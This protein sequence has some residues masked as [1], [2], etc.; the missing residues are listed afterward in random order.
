MKYIRYSFFAAL[1]CAFCQMAVAQVRVKKLLKAPGLEI[2]YGHSYKGH[3]APYRTTA[4]VVGDEVEV[5]TVASEMADEGADNAMQMA[6]YYDYRTMMIYD[7]ATLPSGRRVSTAEA[8][9]LGAGLTAVEGTE[10]ILGLQCQHLRAV[11]NSNTYDV[12]VTHDLP[13]CN[14]SPSNIAL[15]E[16]LVLRV[17]RNGDMVTEAT[18]IKPLAAA[19]QIIPT[20]RGEVMD[21]YE[22]RYAVNRAGVLDV[23]VF[24]QA[25]VAFTGEKLP[26][27]VT[28]DEIYHAGGGTVVLRKVTLPEC[29]LGYNVYCTTTQYSDGDAYDRVGSV[30]VIP[31]ERK[32]SFLDMLRDMSSVPAQRMGG[33]DYPGLISTADYAV[34]LELQRFFTGFGV[35][36]YNDRNRIPGVTWADSVTY[37]TDVTS[38][39][40]YLQGEVWLG[41]YVGNWDAKG[42]RLSV[43]LSYYPTGGERQYAAMPLFNTVNYAEQ[44]G[45]K[46][47]TFML[48]DSLTTTFTLDHDVRDAVLYYLTSGHGGWGGGDEF[49]QKIN[50][51]W[52]DGQK[53][54]A[55]IPWRDDCATYR[56]NNPCSGDAANGETSS[57]YSR[58]NWCPG[59]VTNPEYIALGDLKAGQHT[60]SVQIPQGAPEGGSNS[61]WCISGT[62]LYLPMP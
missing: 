26:A 50:T 28:A 49:N 21:A 59:T 56:S 29:S 57:D 31:T 11:H 3:Q 51:I 30:F 25:R 48:T 17:V 16:G 23:R 45:Q 47:P 55:F 34:P 61:Y 27:D 58:S 52:L 13:A 18:A 1:L 7:V 40:S 44:A 22:Y 43:T 54:A 2:V 20:D 12:W 4:I 5:K 46:Y 14:A 39:S 62:L 37:K 15:C 33:E 24:D 36:A 6:A 8:F 60:L 10:R 32:Q 35:H 41:A 38:L 53:V 42:H 19:C 9:T